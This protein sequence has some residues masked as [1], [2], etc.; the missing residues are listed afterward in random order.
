MIMQL[1]KK[2]EN[3]EEEDYECCF[4]GEELEDEMDGVK[5]EEQVFF[6]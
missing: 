6:C 2:G 5:I 4:C 3:M 1:L